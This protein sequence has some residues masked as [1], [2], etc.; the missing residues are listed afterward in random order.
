MHCCW[1]NTYLLSDISDFL[2]SSYPVKLVVLL[3]GLSWTSWWS[4][5]WVE[6]CWTQQVNVP[7][8]TD[9]LLIGQC[10]LHDFIFKQVGRSCDGGYVPSW[11]DLHALSAGSVC[12]TRPC[13]KAV[14]TGLF[15]QRELELR[16]ELG[17]RDD[18][19]EQNCWANSG[20]S[21]WEENI[22][23]EE[24]NWP[25]VVGESVDWGLRTGYW[26]ICHFEDVRVQGGCWEVYHFTTL[27][28][29]KVILLK[30]RS[31]NECGSLVGWYWQGTLQYWEKH[32]PQWHFVRQKYHVDWPG[33][34]SRPPWWGYW[35]KYWVFR[36]RK[37]QD[38]GENYTS[39][40]SI[41]F[42]HQSLLR[43]SNEVGWADWSC[44]MRETW[45]LQAC[46]KV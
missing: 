38:G 10:I 40:S 46:T 13:L 31:V 18:K 22:G 12:S 2:R 3:L 5:S 24:G 16:V 23:R 27:P 17:S 29:A 9:I 30:G 6:T 39:R 7:R 14:P 25:I 28:V 4:P 34:E 26:E 36:R 43:W 11:C 8:T 1:E 33:V 44:S 45:E 37:W 32:L 15:H 41:I 21:W 19:S 42:L 20:I 35:G